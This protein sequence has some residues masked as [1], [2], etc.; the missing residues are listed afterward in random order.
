MNE[1]LVNLHIHTHYSDGTGSHRE[2]AE[3][4]LEVGLDAVI[5]TDHNVLVQ[6]LD[7]YYENLDRRVLLLTG[8]EIHDV[9]RDP[10]K[11]HLLVL[12]AGRELADQ[13]GDPQQLIQ[14]VRR[15]G[16]LSFLAHP[17]DP[18]APAVGE[19]DISWVDWKVTGFTGIELWNGFSEFKSRIHSKAHAVFYAYQ[20]HRIA[21]G[22][23]P[24]TLKLWDN[25]LATGRKVAAVGGSDAHAL[26]ASLG[27]L[28]RTLFPYRFHFQA[29]NTHVLTRQPLSGVVSADRD[30]LLGAL[31]EGHAFIGY[32]LPAD[33]RGFRFKAVGK[34]Q[35]AIMG[36]EI[37]AR[38]GVTL[39]ITLPGRADCRLIKDGIELKTW[40]KQ[41]VIAHTTAEPGVYR[42]EATLPYLGRKRGWI[43]SNPIYIRD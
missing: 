36:D 22:P 9:H 42:V 6:G 17:I 1:Y 11:N 24:E 23:L 10:Q 29:V 26:H 38:H 14:A 28:K 25:L 27:P 20:P 8:E 41:E 13:A 35:A 12:G 39:Q 5:V 3:A 37:S 40:H 4:A 43:F 32:D 30:L 7:G 21:R 19:P 18:A 31:R 15:S 2:V 34:N 33:T 16:G